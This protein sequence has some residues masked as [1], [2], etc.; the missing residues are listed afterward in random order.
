MTF[1]VTF[2]SSRR[3]ALP[4]HHSPAQFNFHRWFLP[5]TPRSKGENHD[6]QRSSS[7]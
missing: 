5:S 1:G 3:R 4:A 7:F 2:R 6:D